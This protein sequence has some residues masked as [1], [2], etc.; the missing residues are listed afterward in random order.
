VLYLP[1][2][3]HLPQ[4]STELP[5]YLSSRRDYFLRCCLP[6]RKKLGINRL[7]D[8]LSLLLETFDNFL[9]DKPVKPLSSNKSSLLTNLQN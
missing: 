1:I 7:F 3:D 2:T 8:D 5:D 6:A 4:Q 9:G